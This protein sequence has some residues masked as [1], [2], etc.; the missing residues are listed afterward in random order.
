MSTKDLV[1]VFELSTRHS[2]SV[3]AIGFH[4]H[5]IGFAHHRG[6]FPSVAV[7]ADEEAGKG[8]SS[9]HIFDVHIEVLRRINA[10]QLERSGI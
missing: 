1:Q 2:I 7:F 10:N 3:I 8:F 4:D 9:A 6:F 5:L